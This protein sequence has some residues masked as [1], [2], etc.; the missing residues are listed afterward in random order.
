M[1]A[2]DVDILEDLSSS[3]PFERDRSDDVVAAPLQFAH[4]LRKRQAAGASNQPC[5]SAQRGPARRSRRAGTKVSLKSESPVHASK[6]KFGTSAGG[7]QSKQGLLAP[8]RGLMLSGKDVRRTG[9]DLPKSEAPADM[10]DGRTFESRMKGCG[11]W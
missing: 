2:A 7:R 9:S 1:G 10:A 8:S 6:V 11:V 4:V 5:L 3:V